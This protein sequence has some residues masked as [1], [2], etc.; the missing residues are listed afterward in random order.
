MMKF[1]IKNVHEWPLSLRSAVALL[2]FL[3]TLYLGYRFDLSGKSEQLATAEQQEDDLKLQYEALSRKKTVL[4]HDIS[5]LPGLQQQLV[6]WKKSIIKHEE[7]AELLN[8]ILKNASNNHLYVSLFDPDTVVKEGEYEKLPIK[9][10]VV[11]SYHQ[12]ADFVSQLANLPQL[13]V[14]GD[15]VISNENKNDILGSK[16]AQQANEQKLLTIEMN[17]AVYYIPEAEVNEK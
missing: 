11:G 5:H 2:V 16:L 12:L 7:L 4:K 1:N 13:V 3:L 6:E 9:V 10:I 15:F 8:T 14:I 17:L